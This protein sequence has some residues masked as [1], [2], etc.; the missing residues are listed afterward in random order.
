M[1]MVIDPKIIQKSPVWPTMGVETVFIP[2]IEVNSVRGKVMKA[3]IVKIFIISFCF[4]VRSAVLVSR[5]SSS[6]STREAVRL[7]IWRY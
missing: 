5:K 3:R 6:V 4:V 1:T 2:N 7:K